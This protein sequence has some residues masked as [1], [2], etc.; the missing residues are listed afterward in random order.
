MTMSLYTIRRQSRSSRRQKKDA[1]VLGTKFQDFDGILGRSTSNPLG[2]A[3]QVFNGPDA[4]SPK[5]GT[6]CRDNH[7]PVTSRSN[8]L[9]IRYTS[10][11]EGGRGFH[12]SYHTEPLSNDGNNVRQVLFIRIMFPTFNT[13]C[14]RGFNTQLGQGDVVC[15]VCNT[16]LRGHRGVIESPG[17]PNKYPHNLHCS[18]IIR[19]PL[20]NNVTLA[21][22]HIYLEWSGS[23]CRYDRIEVSWGS[24][25]IC[26]TVQLPQLI[27]RLAWLVLWQ[28]FQT[29]H[30]SR[31][32]TTSAPQISKAVYCGD[33][34]PL[35]APITI[36][37]IATI[38]FTSDSSQAF[39]GFRLE[40]MIQGKGAYG[41]DGFPGCGGELTKS[42]GDFAS[43]NYPSQYPNQISC[44][45]IIRGFPGQSVQ[46]TIY[47]LNLEGDPL[48]RFDY[49]KVRGVSP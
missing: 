38:N 7:P 21:F 49:L 14:T 5:M 16:E 24:C 47:D 1:K 26:S 12:L 10:D 36:N 32:P 41:P 17:F 35:P 40:W 25:G 31:F 46:L 9:F 8:S 27:L 18:W 33:L 45:W 42:Y 44:V 6:Y 28:I 34:T 15:A 20:G 3:V 22:S 23:D 2:Y 13:N 43:P 29:A 48:C 19:P 39:D 30:P 37:G 4:L 11:S